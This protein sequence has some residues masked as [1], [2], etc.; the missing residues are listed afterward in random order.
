MLSF[1]HIKASA[2]PEGIRH[3]AGSTAVI[4]EFDCFIGGR[5]W[6][7]SCQI[8]LFLAQASL[9]F[10]DFVL[11]RASGPNGT[12][13]EQEVLYLHFIEERKWCLSV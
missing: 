13:W 8:V 1:V 2:G 5:L 9:C 11:C 4:V 10:W 12:L 6:R 3:T 7:E